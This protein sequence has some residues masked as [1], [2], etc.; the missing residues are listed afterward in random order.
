M[1]ALPHPY[2]AEPTHHRLLFNF[3]MNRRYPVV[4][5]SSNRCLDSAPP[6]AASPTISP[7]LPSTA[8]P[9]LYKAP[10]PRLFAP[11]HFAP[12]NS[13]SPRLHVL[14]TVL[15]RRHF[16]LSAAGLSSPS[17]QPVKPSVRLPIIPSHDELPRAH[18]GESAARLR[19][20]STVDR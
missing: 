14:Y 7:P 3:P 6:A 16:F 4:S 10:M 2:G 9:P 17:H 18:S 12:S 1:D 20:R 15:H 19:R 13:A 5:P 8:S 11:Q